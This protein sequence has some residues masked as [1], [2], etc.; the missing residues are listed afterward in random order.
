MEESLTTKA[1]R[2]RSK[3]TKKKFLQ[4]IV[5]RV[6]GATVATAEHSVVADYDK[7]FKHTA[8]RRRT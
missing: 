6:V 7:H 1:R 4:R 8:E 2:T 5:W 3:I